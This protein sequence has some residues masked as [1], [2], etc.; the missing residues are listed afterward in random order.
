MNSA[1]AV[2]RCAFSGLLALGFGV[3][4][5]RRQRRALWGWSVGFGA[6]ALLLGALSVLLGLT[7]P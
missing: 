5:A 3:A 2:G 4:A 6:L 7:L 1:S